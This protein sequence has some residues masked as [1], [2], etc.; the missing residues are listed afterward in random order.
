MTHQVQTDCTVSVNILP[1]CFNVLPGVW[2]H[3]LLQNRDICILP[4]FGYATADWHSRMKL[5]E[6]PKQTNSLVHS[7]LCHS[8]PL[9][10]SVTAL[11]PV[12]IHTLK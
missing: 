5:T 4:P 6:I 1:V 12:D 2:L 3:P 7:K 9:K 10:D 11:L 8:L